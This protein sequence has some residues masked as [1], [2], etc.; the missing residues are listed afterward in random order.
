MEHSGSQD[1]KISRA[2]N[3]VFAV[4]LCLLVTSEAIL[5]KSYQHGDENIN[6]TRMA[7]ANM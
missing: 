3:S 5:V 2:R 4:K 1:S 6:L 7:L